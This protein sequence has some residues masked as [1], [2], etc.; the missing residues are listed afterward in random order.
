MSDSKIQI[1]YHL[2]GLA[3]SLPDVSVRN[4]FISLAME[5][6]PL[7]NPTIMNSTSTVGVSSQD[8]DN[9]MSFL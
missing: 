7:L 2:S 1:K 6:V 4:N 9:S 3:V 5:S 8:Q